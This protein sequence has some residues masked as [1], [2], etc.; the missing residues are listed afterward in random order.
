MKEPYL[1]QRCLLRNPYPKR[2]DIKGSGTSIKKELARLDHLIEQFQQLLQQYP[3]CE[4][5]KDILS[6]LKTDRAETATRIGS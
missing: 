5:Y 6:R 1:I 4:A 2:D 3:E